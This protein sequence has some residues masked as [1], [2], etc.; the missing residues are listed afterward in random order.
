MLKVTPLAVLQDNYI[1]LIQDTNSDSVA[2]VD[3]GDGA[4]VHAYL[5]KHNLTL[6]NIFITHHHL[7]HTQGIPELVSHYRPTVFGPRDSEVEGITHFIGEG[8]EISL[9]GHKVNVIA[10]P[11]HTLDHL[12]YLID[13]KIFHLFCG[14]TLFSAGCGK[15]LEGTPQEMFHTL[16]KIKKLPT[17][18]LIYPAHEYSMSN[19]K[20]AK[21]VEPSNADITRIYQIYSNKVNSGQ[22]TLPSDIQTELLINP[23]LRTNNSE[24]VNAI[25]KRY[26]TNIETEI[27]TFTALRAWKDSY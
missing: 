24:I 17:N 18:T 4:T 1:W 6:S 26:S 11:G 9:F 21:K 12:L 20:F 7:D 2:V 8:D 5:E 15:L 25:E 3:P 16:Q 27:Q 13:S 14:D 19:L 10:A 23:F 22:S